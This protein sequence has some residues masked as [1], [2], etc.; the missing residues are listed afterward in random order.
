MGQ[1]CRLPNIDRDVARQPDEP[2]GRGNQPALEALGPPE[3]RPAVRRRPLLGTVH[4]QLGSYK[5]SGE[6]ARLKA[7]KGQH[8]LSALGKIEFVTLKHG[9]KALEPLEP[10][11]SRRVQG[12]PSPSVGLAG[13]ALSRRHADGMLRFPHH[14]IVTLASLRRR[15]AEYVE[16]VL[17]D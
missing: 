2:R 4:P 16:R 17:R 9:L 10:H 8:T 14:R 15:Q 11:V 12:E 6:W 5:R 1:L 7:E 3:R 13:S